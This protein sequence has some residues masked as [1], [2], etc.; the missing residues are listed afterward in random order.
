MINVY[1]SCKETADKYNVT[2]SEGA[3]ILSFMKIVEGMK[4]Q[5]YIW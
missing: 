4:E 1:D 3:N 2:I 5:G